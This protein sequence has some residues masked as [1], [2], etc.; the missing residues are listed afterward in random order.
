MKKKNIKPIIREFELKNKII[1]IKPQEIFK[2]K[3]LGT[4]GYLW[5]CSTPSQ[6]KLLKQEVVADTTSFGGSEL[7]MFSFVV[8]TEGQYQLKFTLERPWS[9]EIGQEIEFILEVKD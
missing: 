4:L 1:N 6:V 3:L 8:K 7:D 2:I 9:K 5:K